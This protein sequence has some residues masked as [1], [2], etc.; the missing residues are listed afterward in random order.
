MPIRAF[1]EC[2]HDISSYILEVM[3]KSLIER[4]FPFELNHATISPIIKDKN[5][6]PDELK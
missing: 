5:D 3:N 1:V 4:V 2:F 6:D